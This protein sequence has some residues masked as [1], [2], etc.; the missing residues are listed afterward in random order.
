MGLFDK[1]TGGG[2]SAPFNRQEAFAGILLSVVASDGHISDEEAQDFNA[3]A[4]RMKLFSEQTGAQFSQMIDRLFQ[5]L[6]K[7]GSQALMQRSAQ[8]LPS[9]LRQTA[10]AVATDLVFADGTVDED[11]QALVGELQRV[12]QI[13]DDFAERA[14]EILHIKN[15]G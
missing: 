9:D 1:F 4:N 3:R 11:E 7:E 2:V 8:A 13:P 10:F 15:R 14:V 5:I 12:L 6:R